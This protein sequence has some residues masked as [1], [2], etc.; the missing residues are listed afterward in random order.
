MLCPTKVE[1]PDTTDCSK[2]TAL[3]QV[4]PLETSGYLD[5]GVMVIWAIEMHK[6]QT[7]SARTTSSNDI[8]LFLRWNNCPTKYKY[9]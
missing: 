2:D 1:Y 9:D 8:D 3:M 7:V 4:S 5:E 6:G